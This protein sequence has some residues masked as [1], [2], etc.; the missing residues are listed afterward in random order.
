MKCGAGILAV[1]ALLAAV[2]DGPARAASH[3]D[4]PLIKQ[5]PQDRKS[6]RLNSSH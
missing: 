4:A 2:L 1:A 5:D 3:S 6:T